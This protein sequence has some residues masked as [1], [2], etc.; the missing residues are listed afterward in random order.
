MITPD[1]IT[2]HEL[3][4]LLV[5]VLGATDSGLVGISGEIT[6]ET[7]NTITLKSPTGQ[8]TVAKEKTSLLIHTDSGDELLVNGSLLLGRPENRIKKRPKRL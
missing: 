7:R 2:R 4:G 3:L 1:N 5:K 6:G 8:K